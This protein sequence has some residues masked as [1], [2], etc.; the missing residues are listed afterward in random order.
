MNAEN[1]IVGVTASKVDQKGDGCLAI[2]VE[3]IHRF[4]KDA[5][6]AYKKA[7]DFG[8]HGI[9]IRLNEI[10]VDGQLT[11]PKFFTVTSYNDSVEIFKKTFTSDP[12][13]LNRILRIDIEPGKLINGKNVNKFYPS[14]IGI[15]SV[16]KNISE[17]TGEF[18]V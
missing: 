8:K 16:L 17:G 4:L 13:N 12:E 15:D 5:E 7:Q 14:S 18:Q 3:Q 10:E 9:K 1:K 6:K 2:S 11:A